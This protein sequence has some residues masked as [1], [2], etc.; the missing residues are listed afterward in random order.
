MTRSEQITQ[1]INKTQLGL[2]IAPWH[3]P[4]TPKKDGWNCLS[5]DIFDTDILRTRSQNDENLDPKLV[6]NIEPVDIVGSA[7]ELETLISARGQ[8]GQFDYIISSH[9]FEHLPNPIKF[10]QA[11]G[12]VLKVGGMLSMAIPDRRGTFDYFR[13]VSQMADWLRAYHQNQQQPDPYQIFAHHAVNAR[14]QGNIVFPQNIDPRGALANTKLRAHYAALQQ[15]EN[16]WKDDY[17]DVHCSV[18]VPASFYLLMIELQYLGLS[19]LGVIQI[20][21]TGGAEFFVHLKNIGVQLQID[22]EKFH[23]LRNTL[24]HA[25][26]DEVAS[27]SAYSFSLRQALAHEQAKK[28]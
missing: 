4:I 6:E 9:N 1:F 14:Y 12:K 3:S 18:F 11:C 19:P 23:Q 7:S 13:P 27:N 5:V 22:E 21:P 8:M 20:T 16:Q 28:T 10:L 25:V 2:E 24:M 17:A 15:Q 26:I